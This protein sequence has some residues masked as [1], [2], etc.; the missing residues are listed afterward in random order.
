MY[1]M[2]GCSLSELSSFAKLRGL[3][4]LDMARISMMGEED[5]SESLLGDLSIDRCDWYSKGRFSSK[6]ADGIYGGKRGFI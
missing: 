6:G 3:F 5:S 4:M 2:S 1:I